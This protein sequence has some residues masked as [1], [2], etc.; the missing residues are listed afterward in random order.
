MN[1]FV[2]HVDIEVLHGD[3]AF[4]GDLQIVLLFDGLVFLL[5]LLAFG[6]GIDLSDI[7][8]MTSAIIVNRSPA[9]SAMQDLAAA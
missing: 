4:V 6:V 8:R 7:F 5:F 2:G 1:S 3:D 9:A